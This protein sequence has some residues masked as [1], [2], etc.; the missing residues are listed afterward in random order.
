[1]MSQ[2]AGP[3][4]ASEWEDETDA[5]GGVGGV[6]GVDGPLGYHGSESNPAPTMLPPSWIGAG[7]LP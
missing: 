5:E 3:E 4:L 1:M 7:E 2:Y 6:G